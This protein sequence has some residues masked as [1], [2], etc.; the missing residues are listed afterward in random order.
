VTA[1]E[2]Y[3][4]PE[5][6]GEVLYDLPF[7]KGDD[8]PR[9]F[10]VTVA[11]QERRNGERPFT[12]VVRADTTQEAWA[13]VLAWHFLDQGDLDSYIVASQSRPGTPSPD[14]EIEWNDLRVVQSHAFDR[15]I[16]LMWAK[17]LAERYAAAARPLR[18]NEGDAEQPAPGRGG[19]RAAL[20][21]EALRLIHALVELDGEAP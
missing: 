4:T 2:N 21:E 11:G 19:L 1:V 15:D 12:Y 20:G 5:R 9:D 10:T 7:E 16:Q 14:G 3:L 17:D 18:E 13:I 6:F 8:G